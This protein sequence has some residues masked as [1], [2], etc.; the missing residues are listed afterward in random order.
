MILAACAGVIMVGLQARSV[1]LKTVVLMV[2]GFAGACTLGAAFI[3][4]WRTPMLTIRPD[5]VIVPTFLGQRTIPMKSGHPLG[6][7]LASSNRGSTQGGTIEDN[8]YV[9]FY[10]LDADGALTELVAMHRAAPEIPQIRRAFQEVAG[11]KP[12]T[13]KADP[14]T[15]KARPDVAH[16]TKT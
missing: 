13:L 16:W 3:N 4:A 9:H 14:K 5:A 15:K 8:K 2:L 10:T 7:F 6:E 1:D 11:K 12:E